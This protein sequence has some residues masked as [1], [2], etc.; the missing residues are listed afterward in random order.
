MDSREFLKLAVETVAEHL[1]KTLDLHPSAAGAVEPEDVYVVWSCKTLQ[2]AKAILSTD[3]VNGILYEL[4]YN[5]D[6]DELYLDEYMKSINRK[7]NL[8]HPS[9]KEEK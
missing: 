2:N 8:Y 7:I 9:G 4:T 3:A 5:G 1:N 6:K